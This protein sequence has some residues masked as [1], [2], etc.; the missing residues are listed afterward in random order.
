MPCSSELRDKLSKCPKSV[1]Q[2]NFKGQSFYVRLIGMYDADSLRVA[3]ETQGQLFK[4]MTRLIGIDTPE[5]KSKN[6]DEHAAAVRARD[7]VAEWAMPHR[8]TTGGQYS[9]K[10]L[11]A[12][13]WEEPIIVYVKCGELDKYGRLLATFFRDE[14]DGQQSLNDMLRE[15]GFADS[16]DGGRKQRSWDQKPFQ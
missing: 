12:A 1:P 13:L 6:A 5:I 8:F 4:I 10:Q 14:D 15:K 3:F 9:E 16:Y 2:F 11:V 7:C